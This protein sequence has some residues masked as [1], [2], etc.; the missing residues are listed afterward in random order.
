MLPEL[1]IGIIDRAQKFVKRRR[2]TNWPQPVE[3][4]AKEP[5]VILRE[6]THRDDTFGTHTELQ[7]LLATKRLQV[8]VVPCEAFLKLVSD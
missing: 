7:V 1:I 4:G 5:Y 6:Q 3:R 2:L 8:S